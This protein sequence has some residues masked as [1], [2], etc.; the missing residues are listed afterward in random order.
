MA[1]WRINIA[2][3]IL[4]FNLLVSQHLWY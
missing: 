4:I 1:T 3:L 2:I